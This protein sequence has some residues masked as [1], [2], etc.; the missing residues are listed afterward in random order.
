MTTAFLNKT[1][2]VYKL[3]YKRASTK[4]ENLVLL[5]FFFIGI[6]VPIFTAGHII[7]SIAHFTFVVIDFTGLA[8]QIT[9][10]FTVQA[11]VEF[12]AIG[13]M[14]IS[15]M[16]NNLASFIGFR[17]VFGAFK[18]TGRFLCL[19]RKKYNKLVS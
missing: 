15:G 8:A 19:K 2:K 4:K 7:G 12:L 11:H 16:S 1:L 10:I 18:T 14:G 17:L 5:A 6:L 9:R 13:R 3:F